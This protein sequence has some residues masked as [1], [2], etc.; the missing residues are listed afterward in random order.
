M[1]EVQRALPKGW[2]LSQIS[3]IAPYV[4]RG[5]SPKYKEKSA[6]PV[7]NQKCIRWHGVEKKHVKYIHPDQWASLG[8]ERYLQDEDILWNS[9]GTG[10]IGRACLYKSKY[11]EKA[12]VD[13]HV[14]IVRLSKKNISSRYVFYFIASPYVQK[15]IEEMQTGSTNQVELGRAAINQTIIPLAPLNEQKRIVSKIEELFSDLD[16][17][18]ESLRQAQRL[19]ATYRQSVLK[20]AVTGELTRDWRETNKHRLESGEALLKRILKTR[21]EQ[22]QG[23]GKYKEPEVL[24]STSLPAL[25]I[26]WAWCSLEALIA[27]IITGPFGSALHKTDYINNGVPLINPIN[28]NNEKIIPDPEV[29]VTDDT[30][31]RLARFRV[32]LG[33]VIMGRRGEMGRCAPITQIEEGWLCGTGSLILRPTAM[34][35]SQYL[36]MYISSSQ[37]RHYLERNCVGTTMKNLNQQVL[38]SIAVAL[39]CTLEEQEEAMNR[40]EDVYSQISALETWCETELKRS[41]TLRQSILKSA[42]SGKLVPQDATDEPASELLKRIQAERTTTTKPKPAAKRGRKSKQEAA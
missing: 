42:F 18:E 1:S 40:V 38:N 17:G 22:W 41:N 32:K 21:R 25:P 31:K 11:F 23:R 2:V 13:S 3:D 33:D 16:K 34:I 9:T 10:T 6:L 36:S 19:L 24:D 5:K 12:V 39:P 15:K 20:A 27:E 29:T 35:S 8:H 4:Q 28:I 26:G 30:L 7:I 14:T 37:T